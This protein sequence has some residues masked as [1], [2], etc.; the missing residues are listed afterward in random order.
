[1]V[2]AHEESAAS[3][4]AADPAFASEASAPTDDEPAAFAREEPAPRYGET[5]SDA[6]EVF[7]ASDNGTTTNLPRAPEAGPDT[8]VSEAERELDVAAAPV[9]DDASE[10]RSEPDPSGAPVVSDVDH[11]ADRD[12]VILEELEAWLAAIKR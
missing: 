9:A 10:Y 8:L 1:L 6:T 4:E 11:L 5:Q 7:P 12:R 3:P 2:P